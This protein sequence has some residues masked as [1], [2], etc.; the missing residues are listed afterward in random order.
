MLDIE[1]LNYPH[2]G[3]FILSWFLVDRFIPIIISLS[4]RFN[5]LDRPGGYKQHSGGIPYLGGIGVFLSVTITII[6]ALRFEFF[7]FLKP[8]IWIVICTFFILVVGI[9]DDIRKVNAII[10]LIILLGL[11]WILYYNGVRMTI[12]SGN[13]EFLNIIISTL[14]IAGVASAFNSIDNSDGICSGITVIISFFMFLIN[15]VYYNVYNSGYWKDIHKILSYGA[16]TLCG[17]TIGF[18]RY[19]FPPAKIFLGD[20]GSLSIGFFLG[21]ISILGAWSTSAHK[22]F[23]IPLCLLAVPL[24]DITFTTILRV[25][26]GWVKSVAEAIRWC[27]NDHFAHRLKALGI[28]NRV[29]AFIIYVFG[30]FCGLI[31][32]VVSN[33]FISDN[34]FF[35]IV[36]LFFVLLFLLML[37]LDRIKIDISNSYK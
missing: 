22:S 26:N 21:A 24:F 1:K 17:A 2:I 7:M 10:K 16:I 36:G 34:V 37:L 6:L 23:F 25:K 18:L 3:L 33:P 30:I 31:T 9:I 11:T 12:F 5:L 27:G 15:W 35:I 29:V 20:N 19:N 13:L 8:L 4:H 28:S 14:W 32:F